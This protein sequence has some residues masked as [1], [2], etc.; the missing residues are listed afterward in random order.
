VVA[1][2]GVE[3][4]RLDAEAFQEIIQKRP[5]IAEP[6]AEILARRRVELAAVKGDL[7][8]EAQR[9]RLAAAK[10]DMLDKIR[11]FFGLAQDDAPRRAAR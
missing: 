4:Y 9:R 5:A 8:Q 11:N 10:T 3:C 2:T 7:D 6:V 1:V